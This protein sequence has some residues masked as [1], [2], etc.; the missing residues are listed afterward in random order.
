MR[1]FGAKNF[2]SSCS[3]LL[4]SRARTRMCMTTVPVTRGFSVMG[5]V[6]QRAQFA[7][8]TFSPATDTEAEFCACADPG[9][10]AAGATCPIA[11]AMEIENN[12]E[13]AIVKSQ[14]LRGVSF[15]IFSPATEAR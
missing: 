10:L 14:Y 4:L 3:S 8:K 1:Y 2:K 15:M 7:A 13:T 12:V 6:W 5:A 11:A 9:P